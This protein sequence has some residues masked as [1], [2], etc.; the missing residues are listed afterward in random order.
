MSRRNYKKRRNEGFILPAPI[1]GAIVLLSAVALVYVW[2]GCQ[3]DALGKEIQALE[4]ERQALAKKLDNEENKWSALKAPSSIEKA[5]AAHG[6]A[7]T[8]PGSR[9]VI[10]L[11]EADM[12]NEPFGSSMAAILRYAKLDR[13]G[14]N[15]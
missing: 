12:Q 7:M 6:I 11:T 4:K 15:D 3:C 8:W 5:L 13:G 2:L 10:R 14:R 1:A 9:Q